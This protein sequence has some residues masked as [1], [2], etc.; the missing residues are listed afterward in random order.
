MKYMVERKTDFEPFIVDD[1]TFEKHGMY[2]NG[3]I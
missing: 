3:L 2:K 1:T